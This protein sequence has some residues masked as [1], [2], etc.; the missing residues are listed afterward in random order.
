MD[1]NA[2]N[3]VKN[4]VNEIW[5][6]DQNYENLMLS[7][8]GLQQI[9]S[10][11][12]PLSTDVINQKCWISGIYIEL[13]DFDRF[14]KMYASDDLFLTKVLKTFHKGVFE[15]LIS[16]GI[17]V[18]NVE[19]D[20][21]YAVIQ[22]NTKNSR[23]AMNILEAAMEISGFLKLFWRAMPF[24]ISIVMKQELI[25]NIKDPITNVDQ[26]LLAKN[27]LQDARDLLFKTK[28]NNI[29]IFDSAFVKNNEMVLI[30]KNDLRR[31]YRKAQDLFD[32]KND[33]Y[34]CPFYYRHW[35]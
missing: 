21:I 13:Q 32:S 12:Q 1:L 29:I 4:K 7:S 20:S 16:L 25:I 31:Y 5:R 22:S 34:Y 18:I 14:C 24:K 33:V 17:K 27:S 10:F 15:I 3:K 26:I 2:V 11:Q 35:E 30:N 23:E 28:K 6:C 19:N 9:N 8:S